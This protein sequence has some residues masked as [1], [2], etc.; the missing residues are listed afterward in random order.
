MIRRL[1]HKIIFKKF[2][3]LVND[4]GV[5]LTL[6]NKSRPIESARV[7][8]I[9]D[10][11]ISTISGLLNKYPKVPL[12]ILADISEQNLNLVNVP[13]VKKN[14]VKKLILR[15]IGK[16]FHKND[17]HNYYPLHYNRSLN[18]GKTSYLTIS[19]ANVA[20]LSEWLE[21]L[22]NFSNYITSV[23]SLPIELQSLKVDLDNYYLIKDFP[24]KTKK[25]KQPV[26]KKDN[27]DE[28]WKM[29]VIQNEIGGIR[30]IVSYN[31]DV[32]FTRMLT[33][34][35][36]SFDKYQIEVLRSQISG[37]IEY[38]RRIGFKD[39]DGIKIFIFCS[40]VFYN[41]IDISKS[42]NYKIIRVLSEDFSNIL[43]KKLSPKKTPSS[44]A[45]DIS[46]FFVNK[47]S[48]LG[49]YTPQTKKLSLIRNINLS[50]SFTALVFTMMITIYILFNLSSLRFINNNIE[51]LESTSNQ[52]LKELNIIREKK[53]GSDLNED[54]VINLAELHKILTHEKYNPL[55]TIINLAKIRPSNIT[56]KKIFWKKSQKN[57]ELDV[58]AIFGVK[59]LSYEEVF[60][61]YD[62]FI[63]K[64]K[65]TFPKNQITHSELPDTINFDLSLSDIEIQFNIKG[66]PIKVK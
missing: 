54:K 60:I 3:L 43:Y 17:L 18:K 25:L 30:I 56:I 21:Y 27:Q 62:K 58:N 31:H 53:F 36:N 10:E 11:N 57:V 38:L 61:S 4:D 49:F 40:D 14:I 39:K 9:K 64:L 2:V 55:E 15:K 22:D 59:N 6:F 48:Y 32:L 33:F 51:K 45:Q 20:P 66:Q 35:K 19:I 13:S 29:V 37:T 42:L 7:N 23:Y 1:L 8:N 47:G 12:Y 63:K 52:L 65:T 41:Q 46:S 34:D 24:K 50:L 5:L 44:I 26:N 16:D 28:K